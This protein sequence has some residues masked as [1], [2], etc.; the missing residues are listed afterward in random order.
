MT[1]LKLTFAFLNELHGIQ[2]FYF[3]AIGTISKNLSISKRGIELG[4]GQQ[5][6]DN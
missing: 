3:S 4:Y 6:L 1:L 2:T 5:K